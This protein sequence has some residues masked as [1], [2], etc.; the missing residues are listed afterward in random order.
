MK[1]GKYY[2]S[3]IIEVASAQGF[4]IQALAKICNISPATMSRHLKRDNSELTSWEAY[5]I[6]QAVAPHLTLDELFPE[7][8]SSEIK[9]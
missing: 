8:K 6:Q 4:T 1:S 7:A 5:Q 9:L 3:T 2:Y